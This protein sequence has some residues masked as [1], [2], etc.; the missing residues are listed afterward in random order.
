[1]FRVAAEECHLLHGVN[2]LSYEPRVTAPCVVIIFSVI[3]ISLTP[4]FLVAV[5][6]V[7]SLCRLAAS[8]LL[9]LFGKVVKSSV[10]QLK[11]AV[12][13]IRA[14][15]LQLWS[16]M[17][18][19]FL[20]MPLFLVPLLGVLVRVNAVHLALMPRHSTGTLPAA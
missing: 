6:Q 15:A 12:R 2:Q 13:H 17:L 11:T 18:A 4:L 8:I 9:K 16:L 10:Q 5:F 7:P 20:C 14:V 1:M 3:T 19:H